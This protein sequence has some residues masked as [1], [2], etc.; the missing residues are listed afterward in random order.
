[1]T[2]RGGRG[3]GD[4]QRLIVEHHHLLGPQGDEG[5]RAAVVVGELDLIYAVRELLHDRSNLSAAQALLPKVFRER[6]D[7]QKMNRRVHRTPPICDQATKQLVN[8]GKSSPARTIQVLRTTTEP[9]T[10]SIVMSTPYRGAPFTGL[11]RAAVVGPPFT[12]GSGSRYRTDDRRSRRF[13]VS[14]PSPRKPGQAGA[15]ETPG[16]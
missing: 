12:A 2:D 9:A 14:S 7:V 1:V 3:S 10:L 16:N 8:R 6:D 13:S 4:S 11:V 15:P 5:V